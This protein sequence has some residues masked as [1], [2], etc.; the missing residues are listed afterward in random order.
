MSWSG[1]RRL[2]FWR[3]WPSCPLTKATAVGRAGCAERLRCTFH[4]VSSVLKTEF[5]PRSLPVDR[6][7]AAD[8]GDGSAGE[9]VFDS[10]HAIAERLDEDG[11]LGHGEHAA[12]AG[13]VM[14]LGLGAY[15]RHD[16]AGRRQ[17]AFPYVRGERILSPPSCAARSSADQAR[18]IPSTC[19]ATKD[20][21][22]DWIAASS[23]SAPSGRASPARGK[24][25]RLGGLISLCANGCRVSMWWA[26]ERLLKEAKGLAGK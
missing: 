13:D 14:G 17:Y 11:D 9:A 25:R 3:S 24:T 20:S 2:G 10:E 5:R 4:F 16:L 1:R 8:A 22:P 15:E 7:L 12:L 19:A 6:R 26:G 21:S 18:R 23:R